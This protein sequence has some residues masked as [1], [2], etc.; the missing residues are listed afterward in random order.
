MHDL[1]SRRYCMS[2]TSCFVVNKM[3]DAYRKVVAEIRQIA[4]SD[5]VSIVRSYFICV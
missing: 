1:T 2:V 5:Y 3:N 4:L